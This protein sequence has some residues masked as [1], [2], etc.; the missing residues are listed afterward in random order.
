M[1]INKAREL[2]SVQA[3]FGGGY[4]R[5]A[6]QLILAE[7]QKD[8]GQQAVDQFISEFN[9]EELFGFTPGKPIKVF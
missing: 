6:T 2:L 1:T 9:F 7:V 8:H 3:S 5:N 4:Q